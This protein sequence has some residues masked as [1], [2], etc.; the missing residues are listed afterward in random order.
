M[1]PV[2]HEFL[3][4]HAQGIAQK[5]VAAQKRVPEVHGLF[6]QAPRAQRQLHVDQLTDHG[7][8]RFDDLLLGA[9]QGDLVAH[10]VEIAQ[11][12]AALAID[13]AGGQ[14]QLCHALIDIAHLLIAGQH[15]QMQHDGGTHARAGV[16][17]TG[18]KIPQLG[19]KAEGAYRLQT[20]FHAESHVRRSFQI[21]ARS[22]GLNAQ[23]ILLVDHDAHAPVLPDQ[24]GAGFGP[25]HKVAA[26]QVLFHQLEPL[27]IGQIAHEVQ[28]IVFFPDH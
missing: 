28:V 20:S 18:G 3:F 1:A 15:G 6:L 23:V 7:G 19:I 2:E 17:G 27:D 22:N 24:R 25:L 26:D 10:L 5:A 9:A 12:L 13:P 14:A 8:Y 4:I 21:Q 16:G 11:S